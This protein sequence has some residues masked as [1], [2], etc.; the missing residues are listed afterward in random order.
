MP[1]LP[2]WEFMNNSGSYPK[3]TKE[4][5]S[6]LSIFCLRTSRNVLEDYDG[7]CGRIL[8]TQQEWYTNGLLPE[9]DCMY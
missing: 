8:G 1:F 9:L 3:L 7:P 6:D 5:T 2:F 4:R